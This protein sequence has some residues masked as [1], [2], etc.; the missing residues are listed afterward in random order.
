MPK[1]LLPFLITAL[2]ASLSAQSPGWRLVETTDDLTG[3]TDRRLIVRA[4]DWP[5]VRDTA[6]VEEYRRATII[7]ACGDRMPGSEGRSLLFF[8]GQPLE[9]FGRELGYVEFRFD[10]R[11]TPIKAFLTI[12][13]YG[14][15]VVT[16]TGRR[17]T[18]QVAYLGAD[19][20]PYFSPQLFSQ[21][22]AAGKLTVKYRAFG[23]EQT[24]SFRL[25]GLREALPQ[26]PGCRWPT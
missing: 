17:A 5:S 26:L 2:C 15:A 22:V 25:S 18:R 6:A 3:A 19:K 4:D 7:L 20:S 13:D 9:P 8:A 12:L 10:G 11:P 23:A 16:A 14:D 1:R 24:V 21:L